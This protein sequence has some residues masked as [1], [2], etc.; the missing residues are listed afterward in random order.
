MYWQPTTKFDGETW[1][2]L[3]G[4]ASAVLNGVVF[5]SIM[6]STRLKVSPFPLLM[7]ISFFESLNISVYVLSFRICSWYH[8]YLLSYTIFFSNE[9]E[10]KLKSVGILMN[11]S[12]FIGSFSVQMSLA[13]NIFL[14]LD[15]ILVI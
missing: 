15:L 2:I 8:D 9:C 13:L 6:F 1:F 7:W 3:M 14:C 10:Y 5:L 4:E 11:A 12:N